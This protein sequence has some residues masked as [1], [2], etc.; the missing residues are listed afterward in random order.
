MLR[1][2]RNC[3]QNNR[4]QALVEMALVLPLLLLI[5]LG[6]IEFGI[7]LN[8]YLVVTAAAR[9]GAR[10]AAVGADNPTI[11]QIAKQTAANIETD[12]LTVTVNPNA[13]AAR[14]RGSTVT[15]TVTNSVKIMTPLISNFFPQDT[16]L[17]QGRVTMR[18][19]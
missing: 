2:I 10:A 16:L 6:T 5:L 8:R 17:V 14:T 9:E 15:V 7:V 3:L 13:A 4:G 11:D 18:M 19:E 12:A 1:R